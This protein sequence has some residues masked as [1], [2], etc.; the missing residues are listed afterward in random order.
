MDKLSRETALEAALVYAQRDI[1]A[2]P[3]D[4]RTKRPLVGGKVDAKTGEKIKK[5]GGLYRATTHADQIQTWWSK[6]PCAMIGVPIPMKT[7]RHSDLMAPWI[8]T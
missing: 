8:P 1:P 3:C 7:P 6:W 2:F 4:P 5:T